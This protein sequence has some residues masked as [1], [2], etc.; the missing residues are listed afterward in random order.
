[1]IAHVAEVWLV[2]FVAFAAGSLLGWLVYRWVDRSDY[3][4][5]QR[6]LSTAL[7]ARFRRRGGPAD[8]AYEDAGETDEPEPLAAKP[9][10]REGRQSRR[11]AALLPPP[12]A[13]DS[14][15]AETLRSRVKGSS[16]AA[17]WRASRKRRASEDDAGPET[18]ALPNF[19]AASRPSI[20]E[21]ASAKTAPA[22]YDA[23]RRRIADAV[24]VRKP[25]EASGSQGG[26]TP[27][28]SA[29]KADRVS[30]NAR[31]A[32]TEDDWAASAGAWPPASGEGWPATE[33]PRLPAPRSAVPPSDGGSLV[34]VFGT[35]LGVDEIWAEDDWIDP[36]DVDAEIA[37]A[38]EMLTEPA[39]DDNADKPPVLSARPGKPDD[40]KK[41]K[42]I[43]AAFEKKLNRLGIYHYAQI[44]DWTPEQQAWVGE[45]FGFTG[46]I[47]RDDWA[48]Q[49]AKLAERHSAAPGD[50]E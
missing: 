37:E 40:L 28:R 29:P 43:G 9:G 7:G 4:F 31:T 18:I 22:D 41:I 2:L 8:E 26:A 17:S 14:V 36:G 45:F 21:H 34:T 35:D 15:A 49:A 30:S 3:A 27:S 46:R 38:A 20:A 24:R 23:P 12:K 19:S 6:E 39:T 16:L 10:R 1:M 25:G 5:D 47:E 13:I 48:T 33:V 42:G 11:Q 50:G 32:E 44:A